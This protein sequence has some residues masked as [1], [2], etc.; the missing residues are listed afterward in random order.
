[1]RNAIILCAATLIL[2]ACMVG[3]N[4]RRPPVPIP[5]S[6]Q[7][8]VSEQAKTTPPAAWWEVFQDPTL[9]DLE[10][11]AAQANRDIGI[12]VARLDQSD[13]A[14]RTVRADLYPT[15]TAQPY[16]GRTRESRQRPN[17]G[18]TNGQAATYND[19][20][21][22]LTLGYEL[23]FWGRIRRMVQSAAATEQATQ[24][25]LHFVQLTVAASVA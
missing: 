22:P 2:S 21:V 11:Q 23:D 15:L 25:D 19:L 17:N 7:E 5:Q 18:N 16:F 4:Y 13:A 1:M 12:A 9:N 14:R 3:P 10:S 6:F 8:P 24:D 20:Q